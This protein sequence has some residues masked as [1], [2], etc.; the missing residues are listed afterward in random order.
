MG[1]H[2]PLDYF[3]SNLNRSSSYSSLERRV[4]A[5]YFI[6]R[7]ASV[8]VAK[9]AISNGIASVQDRYIPLLHNALIDLG[10][11]QLAVAEARSYG[12]LSWPNVELRDFA[13]SIV[14]LS[15]NMKYHKPASDHDRMPASAI[16]N[17][18]VVLKQFG[19]ALSEMADDTYFCQDLSRV[20]SATRP[21]FE[22]SADIVGNLVVDA[23]NSYCV[24][25]GKQLNVEKRGPGQ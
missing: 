7:E 16:H 12:A 6:M 4:A 11:F 18:G 25:H 15:I 3:R 1:G 2:S 24:N 14:D 20:L 9:V 13:N 17:T 8:F 21:S 5:P 10:G 19:L 23:L 22:L